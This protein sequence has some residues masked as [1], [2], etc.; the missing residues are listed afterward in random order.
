MEFPVFAFVAMMVGVVNGMAVA[1]IL[2]ALAGFAQRR[3]AVRVYWVYGSW[4]FFQLLSHIML[5]WSIWNVQHTTELN[6][7]S[8]LYLISG[9]VVLFLATSILLAATSE[10]DALDTREH[11]FSC[12]RSFFTLW[13]V[14]LIWSV[15]NEP[16]FL[17]GFHE[18]VWLQA[19][20]IAVMLMAR[21]SDK[22]KVQAT[23]VVATYAVQLTITCLY[24]MRLGQF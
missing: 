2:T 3:S 7:L 12:R 22:P 13:V 24:A 11:F 8:Y 15:F 5:W 10:G 17:G 19:I 23:A 1:S 20:A 14:F 4:V 9:P 21:F 16:L 6:F 18:S